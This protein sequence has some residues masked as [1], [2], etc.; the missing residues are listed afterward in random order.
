MSVSTD[1]AQKVCDTLT[2]T[3]K[4]ATEA[5]HYLDDARAEEARANATA[6][7]ATER[8]LRCHATLQAAWIAES[9][10]REAWLAQAASERVIEEA[11]RAKVLD[12]EQLDLSA[13][14]PAKL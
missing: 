4:A 1:M 13:H 9:T 11:R 6:K 12:G 2:A 3:R 14:F 10:A 7:T 8:R 5:E